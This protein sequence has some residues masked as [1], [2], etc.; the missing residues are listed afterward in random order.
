M[1]A[2]LAISNYRSLRELVVPMGRLNLVTGANGSGKS[3]LYRALRLLAET[4]QG[5]VVP[6]LAREGG[7]PSVLWAGPEKPS[8]AMG[9]GEVPIQ[10]G[11]R[12]QSVALRLG[13]AGDEYGYAI[14]MGLPVPSLSMFAL[15]PVIKGEA[16]WNGSFLRAAN[17]LVERRGAMVRVREGRNWRVVAEHLS[18]FES[19]FTQI[20]DPQRAP[21]VLAL[22][23]AIRGWRFY[24]HFRSDQEAPARLPQL[25]TFTPVLS[26]DGRDLAAAWQTI[27]EIGDVHA[28]DAAIEDAF[29]GASVRVAE[30]DG[31]FTLLFS[32]HGLLRP[33]AS[34]ELSDGTL[35]YL[36]WIAALHTPRPPPLMVLNEPET[37]LH[38]DLLPALARLIAQ[39]SRRTQVWVVSHASRLI[40]SLEREPECHTIQLEKQL[41]QTRVARQGMLEAPAW[42]WPQR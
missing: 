38:P 33:L 36:S 6:S 4:A 19:L 22:R 29:P 21:E 8:D 18:P 41:S 37:S 2:T 3:N 17:L 10:G 14:D 12:Q 32:Q 30:T 26:H 16:I 13:F 23:D 28:L 34:S 27:R 5:G 35:R 1:L 25:A 11:P 39:A 24:D 31:R 42:H 9:R 40:A 15:D 7:L 20:A